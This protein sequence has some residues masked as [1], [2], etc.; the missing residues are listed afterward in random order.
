MKLEERKKQLESELKI[1]LEN[2]QRL[3][4]TRNQL[5]SEIIELRGKLNLIEE[6]LKE[7][8]EKK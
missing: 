4:G 7:E 5:S 8:T 3:E 1:K 6:L 2:F